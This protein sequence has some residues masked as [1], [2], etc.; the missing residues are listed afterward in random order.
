MTERRI[1]PLKFNGETIFIEVS[2]IEQDQTSEETSPGDAYED[3]S[4][5]TRLIEAGERVRSTIS[6]LAATVR[7]ALDK[8][9]P[10]EWTLEINLGF[11]GKAGIPFV[12]QGEA[13]GAIKVTAKWQR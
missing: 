10:S 2:E 1:E 8:V 5:E 12:T 9:E 11:K 6:T 7:H 4:A 3:I 13:N